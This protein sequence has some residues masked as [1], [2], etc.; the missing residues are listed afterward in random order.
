M[1]C[2]LP[3]F[4]TAPLSIPSG[5]DAAMGYVGPAG[6]GTIGVLVV[7]VL[8][9]LIGLVGLVLYPVRLILRRRRQ[10]KEPPAGAERE[11]VSA[12]RPE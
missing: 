10:S 7:V 4:S 6:I 3:A 8:V 5:V 12:N 11:T 9:L 2:P 1:T